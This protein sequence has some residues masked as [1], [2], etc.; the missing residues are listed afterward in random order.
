M[1][2][3]YR[4]VFRTGPLFCSDEGALPHVEAF[5]SW[6]DYC[7]K[8]INVSQKSLGKAVCENIS[9]VFL[10]ASLLPKLVQA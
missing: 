10:S 5:F 7:E 9:E 4:F 1:Q 6:L 2:A 8:V 3:C